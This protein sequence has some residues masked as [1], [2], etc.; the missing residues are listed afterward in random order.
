[1]L[2]PIVTIRN[3][4][5]A[6]EDATPNVH[7][8]SLPAAPRA[9]AIQKILDALIL[10]LSGKEV[11]SKDAL[12]K[13]VG[14]LALILKFPPLPQENGRAFVRRLINFLEAMPLPGRLGLEQQLTGRGLA[15]RVAVLA[16]MPVSR[17]GASRPDQTPLRNL[18]LS[19]AEPPSSPAAR[20]LPT[21]DVGLLQALLRKTYGADT[22]SFAAREIFEVK[23]PEETGPN[24]VTKAAASAR[25]PQATETATAL[26]IEAGLE[27]R[28]SAVETFISEDSEGS[29][30]EVLTDAIPVP[31]P[32]GTGEATNSETPSGAA[33]E[34]IEAATAEADTAMA[35]G[36]TDEAVDSLDS[37]GTYGPPRTGRDNA[38][39][40]P[41]A[42]VRSESGS[43]APRVSIESVKAIIQESLLL[44]ATA[45]AEQA[46]ESIDAA[47]READKAPPARESA[48][49]NRHL[50]AGG[51]TPGKPASVDGEDVPPADI[52]SRTRPRQT[53]DDAGTPQALARLV[54]FGLPREIVPF[55]L[56]P[57]PPAPATTEN[58]TDEVDRR[59]RED[60]AGKDARGG[61][62]EREG[63]DQAQEHA[64]G[65]GDQDEEPAATDA[66]DLYRKLGDLG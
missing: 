38:Q 5:G 31:E 23:A 18:P 14:D 4:I 47:L 30:H 17:A 43:P 1:M 6:G 36:S 13:L 40:V 48:T 10:H 28:P 27:E 11:L 57:Y 34:S 12:V 2:M 55:T 7:R 32:A 56:V 33:S 61:E 21:G 62:E 9:E 22:D 19:A 15:Q 66:Y 54:E 51:E 16:A 50:A 46:A 45:K 64:G 42:P 63:R 39:R 24:R 41:R 35:E 8:P 59:E 26:R 44:P 49:P 60:E 29:S 52:L 58:E 20:T 25:S 3:A 37:D 53:G 65:E